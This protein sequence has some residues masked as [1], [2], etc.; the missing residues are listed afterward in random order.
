VRA[1]DLASQRAAPLRGRSMRESWTA[2]RTASRSPD[3]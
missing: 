1:R 2:P 3:T